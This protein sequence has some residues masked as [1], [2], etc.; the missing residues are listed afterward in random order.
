MNIVVILSFAY[1]KDENR[2]WYE[3]FPENIAYF[4]EAQT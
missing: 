2:T 4:T 1:V 3:P